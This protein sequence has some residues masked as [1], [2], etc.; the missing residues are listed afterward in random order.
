VTWEVRGRLIEHLDPEIPDDWVDNPAELWQSLCFAVA[1][2]SAVVIVLGLM[3]V[4]R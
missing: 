1:L 4:V 2:L 3:L